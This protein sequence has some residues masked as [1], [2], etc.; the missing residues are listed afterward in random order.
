[1]EKY[2]LVDKNSILYKRYYDYV[3]HKIEIAP[4]IEKFKL[5]NFIEAQ[6]HATTQKTFYIVPS[7]EDLKKFDSKLTK[8]N[9]NGLRAFKKNSKIGKEYIKLLEKNNIEIIERPDVYF[10]FRTPG[11]FN[12]RLFHAHDSL[13]CSYGS[14]LE[15][16]TPKG[17]KEIKAS[18]FFEIIESFTSN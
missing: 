10:Y 8:E 6:L 11:R 1:M 12:Y 5:E 7:D 18:K 15:F 4:L 9:S 3:N 16:K 14:D 2:Y 17:F 13:Y